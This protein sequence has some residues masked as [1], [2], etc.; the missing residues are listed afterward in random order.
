MLVERGF[1]LDIRRPPLGD[2][3]PETLDGHAGAVVFGGPMSAND[4]DEFVR[5]ET[6]WMRVPLQEK[7]PFLGICLGAQMLAKHLGGKVE[8]HGRGL[9]EIGWYPIEATGNGRQL[10]HWPEMVYQFHREGFTLPSDATLLATAETYPNQAFRYG[11]NAYGISGAGS[12]NFWKRSSATRRSGKAAQ[13]KSA[14]LATRGLS[15]TGWLHERCLSDAIPNAKPCSH[16]CWNCSCR[17][18]RRLL[19]ARLPRCR[20]WRRAWDPC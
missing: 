18:I 20:P 19:P 6:D 2:P 11:E 16:F 12:G 7:K 14:G 4:P 8:G 9:V 15:E 13:R 3:L 10:L 1:D 5:R 17:W